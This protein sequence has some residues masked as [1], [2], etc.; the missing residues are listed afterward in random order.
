[1]ISNKIIS[2]LLAMVMVLVLAVGCT[3]P[4]EP[5][6][7]DP[8]PNIKDRPDAIEPPYTD[9]DYEAIAAEPDEGGWRPLMDLKVVDGKI[10]EVRFDEVDQE[11]LLKSENEEYN[12]RWEAASG[13]S[14]PEAYERLQNDLIEKQDID[15][16]ETVTGATRST[17]QFKLMAKEALSR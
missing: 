4:I 12:Q 16:V 1:M 3:R 10:I 17:E 9:G 7:Q 13:I 6:P 11:G 2:L 15:M 5:Q 8:Q 14:G